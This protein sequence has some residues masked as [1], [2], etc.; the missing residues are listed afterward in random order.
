MER[1]NSC[2]TFQQAPASKAQ[3]LKV[4]L[5]P[6]PCSLATRHLSLEAISSDL[7]SLLPSESRDPRGT[8]ERTEKG[9][10]P[11]RGPLLRC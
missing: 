9:I 2:G 11:K 5:P 3:I 8:E 7:S 6:W 1:V 4:S 10:W